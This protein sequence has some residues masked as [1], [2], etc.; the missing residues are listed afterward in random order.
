MRESNDN[1]RKFIKNSVTTAASLLMLPTL[2]SEAIA[3]VANE[4]FTEEQEQIVAPRIKFSVIGINHG[5]IYGQ[6]E[7]VVRGGGELV[8][9]YAKETDLAAAFTKRYP[10]VKQAASE[11][12]ILDDKSVQLVLSSG[13]P[14]ERAPLGVRVMKSGKDY[15]SDK[16]GITSLEQLAEVRKVQKETKRIYSIMYSER[17]ENRATVK[18]GELV[19]AGAIGKVIQTIGLGPHRI[20]PNSRPEWFF[21]KKRFGGIIC[22]IASHQFDQFLFFTGSTKA[23]VVASQVGNVAHPQYPKFEDFGDTMLRGDG[24][25]GYIRVDW[26]T[27]DGL[28][29]WGDGR[30]TILGTEGY[31]ELRKNIDI[32]GRDGGN[33]LFL[34]NNKETQYIDCSKTELPYGKQ[35][36]DDVINRTETA[37]SQAHCFLATELALKAQ[38]NAQNVHSLK[39]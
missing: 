5:H 30:L 39:A 11:K 13:I 4:T 17:L 21:D 23:E 3:S 34:V 28:K 18:A 22:D 37:M 31:I 15:M 32:A 20:T 29:S 14:D 35:L 9:F 16:P 8:S 6:V 36:V 33:H 1:R 19:K 25:S 27:P 24:G 10:Q 2:P 12:E 7:A 26:F 38:K